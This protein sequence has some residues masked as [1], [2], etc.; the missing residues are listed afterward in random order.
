MFLTITYCAKEIIIH[1]VSYYYQF[2]C[3]LFIL[4][5]SVVFLTA[6]PRSRPILQTDLPKNTTVEIGE[7]AT[8]KCIV[9]VSGTLPDFRWLKWDKSVKSLPKLKDNL[10]NGSYKLIDPHYHATIQV[11]ENYGVELRINNVT[12]DDFGLY[13]CFVS[14]HI[15]KDYNSAFLSRYVKPTHPSKEGTYIVFPMQ[16]CR[17]LWNLLKPP[18]LVSTIHLVR[19]S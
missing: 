12:E 11:G 4:L 19:C 7:N 18:L 5:T 3:A 6:K 15:G 14:N 10:E 1:P 16:K 8:M 9:L 13:T 2:L 17:L